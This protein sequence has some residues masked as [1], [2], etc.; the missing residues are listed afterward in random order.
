MA[1][2]TG[3]DRTR[4]RS[5][6]PSGRR[7]LDHALAGVAFASSFVFVLIMVLMA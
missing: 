7:G 6:L 1:Y 5:Y 4:R 3:L 2:V